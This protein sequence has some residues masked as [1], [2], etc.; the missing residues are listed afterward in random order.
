MS[1]EAIST[2]TA[3]DAPFVAWSEPYGDPADNAASVEYECSLD[4]SGNVIDATSASVS[5]VTHWR[6][7]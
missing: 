4:S 5:N 2:V 7:A 1:W 3:A 6:K